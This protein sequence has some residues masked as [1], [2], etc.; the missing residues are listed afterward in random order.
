MDQQLLLISRIN[1]KPAWHGLLLLMAVMF[2]HSAAM[3]QDSKEG[4]VQ[5]S[6]VVVTAD[7]LKPV[8][9]SHI[10][11][12]TTG[13]GTV[14][15][16]YGY[17]SFVAKK[18]DTIVFSALG[19]KK[20]EFIIPD[21]INDYRYTLFQVMSP[22]TIFLT[23]TVIY[24]WPTKDQFKEAFM[25]LDIPDDDLETAR[26]NLAENELAMR[27]QELHMDGMANYRHSM[28]KTIS[29]NYYAGQLQPISILNPFAWAQFIKAWKEGKFKR[30]KD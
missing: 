20:S 11:D 1:I 21:T 23:E 12:K 29:Q 3:S 10:I 28:D 18:N 24:P 25:N 7:S 4:L 15:D 26:K 9:F 13:F 22:D 14:S 8:S 2:F 6:G 27:A 19:F 30:K 5:F 17:F 16:Y